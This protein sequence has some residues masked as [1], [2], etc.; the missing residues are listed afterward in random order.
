M[1][2]YVAANVLNY[3]TTG[4]WKGDP[5]AGQ[6]MLDVILDR[7]GQKGTG[8]WTA[9][10]AQHLAAPIPVIEAAVTARNLS[11]QLTTRAEGEALNRRRVWGRATAT[12]PCSHRRPN[13]WQCLCTLST[14]FHHFAV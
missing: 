10:E 1:L 4:P 9:I 5:K 6:A 11:A 14:N 12:G 3:V 13:S 7:A 2:V 8:R